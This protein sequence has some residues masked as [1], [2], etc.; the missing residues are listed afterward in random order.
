VQEIKLENFAP[1]TLADRDTI[2]PL[3]LAEDVC[4]C[5]YNFANLFHVGGHLQDP[6]ACCR[7]T[8]CGSTTGMTT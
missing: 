2:R 5:E 7:R 1:V 6:L 3:L 4:F 8:A